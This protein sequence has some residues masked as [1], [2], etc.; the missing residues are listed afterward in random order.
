M[1]VPLRVIPNPGPGEFESISVDDVPLFSN[2][3]LTRILNSKFHN[4]RLANAKRV[5]G[6]RIDSPQLKENNEDH[7][8]TD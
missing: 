7:T 4:A 1:E 3:E 2:E 5:Q 6:E 8:G